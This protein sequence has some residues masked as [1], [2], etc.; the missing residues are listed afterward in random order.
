MAHQKRC[1]I[2]FWLNVCALGPVK[3]GNVTPSQEAATG[4]SSSI[5]AR[6]RNEAIDP[7]AR[8]RLRADTTVES[9]GSKVNEAAAGEQPLCPEWTSGD[10]R[11]A[12]AIV[13]RALDLSG[14]PV[15]RSS[16]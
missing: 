12:A 11:N 7:N 2:V 16:E 5:Q 9:N 4:G 15:R 3:S 1:R 10:R 13:R 8:G 6:R 14:A